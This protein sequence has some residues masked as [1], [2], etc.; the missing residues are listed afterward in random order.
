MHWENSFRK[1]TGVASDIRQALLVTTPPRLLV[2]SVDAGRSPLTVSPEADATL[3]RAFNAMLSSVHP[4]GT[5]AMFVPR[6]W[7]DHASPIAVEGLSSYMLLG[8]HLFNL[9]NL[10]A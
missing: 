9:R 2:L 5:F 1:D 7:V 4:T 8:C 10:A 6:P 3:P